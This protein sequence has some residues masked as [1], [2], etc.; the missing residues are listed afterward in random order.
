[1]TSRLAIKLKRGLFRPFDAN[2]SMDLGQPMKFEKKIDSHANSNATTEQIEF[3]V[4]HH[5]HQHPLYLSIKVLGETALGKCNF[6][7]E[8]LL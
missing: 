2:E 8:A 5:Y 6:H 7:T 4:E 3:E 1:M